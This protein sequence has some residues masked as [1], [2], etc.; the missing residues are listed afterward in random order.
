MNRTRLRAQLMRHEGLRLMPYTDTAGKLTIGVG[1]NLTDRGISEDEA[2]ALLD[3]DITNIWHELTQKC[4]CFG[5]MDE[6]RQH[7]LI[8][9]AFNLGVP[10]LMHFVK[11]MTALEA[12]DYD[13]AAD[14]MLDSKWARQVGKRA[15]TLA[16][17]MRTGVT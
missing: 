15:Q 4:A 8:D 6:P 14:E 1:R 13:R 16:T 17:I 2:S 12:R 9:I 10:A 5:A 11:M 3:N 7:A